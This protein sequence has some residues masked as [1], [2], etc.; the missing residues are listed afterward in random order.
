MKILVQDYKASKAILIEAPY[1]KIRDNFAIVKTLYSAISVG[2]ETSRIRT[3]LFNILLERKDQVELVIKSIKNLGISETFKRVIN[4]IDSYGPLGYSISGI[5]VESRIDGINEGDFVV[6]AGGEYAL[7]AEYNLIPK[8]LIFKIPNSI[9][10]KLASFSTIGA[11][12]LNSIRIS[13]PEIGERF[14]VIGL[15]LIGQIVVRILNLMNVDTIGIDISDYK[16]EFARKY[17]KVY[18]LKRD[19]INIPLVDGVIICAN[20]KTGSAIKLAIDLVREKGRIIVVGQ[21]KLNIPYKEFYYKELEIKMSRAYGAGRYDPNYEIKGID[22]PESYVKWTI[23]RNIKSFIEILPKLNL[24]EIITHE[25]EFEKA[26]EAYEFLKK[27]KNYLGVV[28]KY[29]NHSERNKVVIIKN[30]NKSSKLNLAIIGVGSYAQNVILPNFLKY[31]EITPL[32]LITSRPEN[33]ANL[34]KRYNFK[35]AG[36]DYEEVFKDE[37]VN[38]VIISTP[39]NLH[40]Y[41]T[42]KAILNNKAFYVEKPLTIKLEELEE[43]RSLYEKHP[44]PFLVGFNRRFSSFTKKIEDFLKD[45]NKFIFQYHVNAG[46]LKEHWLLDLNIGGGRLVGEGCHFIDF[47]VYVLGKPNTYYSTILDNENFIISFRYNHGLANIIYHSEGNN[48]L[49]KEIIRIDSDGIS[50]ILKDFKEMNINGSIYKLKKQD[51]GQEKMIELF[52]KSII[53]GKE[54]PMTFESIYYSSLLTLKIW[55]S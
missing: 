8:N 6:G 7:H 28:F 36:C 54:G 18:N 55:N 4:K 22:Y 34:A 5:V 27:E 24:D 35:Y 14:L 30:F 32:Y 47:I 42:K 25:F 16:L 21:S 37:N 19:K 11:I 1:P 23:N 49:E 9:D 46:K 38:L 40:G 31:K 20:D 13:K 45:K 26:Q 29:Q 51:K 50:L 53:E 17:A 2:T 12:A 10:L 44:V 33:A 39:H 48:S 15:G 3:N 43:I 52:V 41:L